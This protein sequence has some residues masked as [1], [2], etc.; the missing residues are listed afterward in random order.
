MDET[1]K[2]ATVRAAWAAALENLR[3]DCPAGHDL[4]LSKLSPVSYAGGVLTV[5][6]GDE[7]TRYICERRLHRMLASELAYTAGRPITL[8]YVLQDGGAPC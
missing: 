5:A 8:Y 2:P 4:Y 3:R 6:A 7:R 1:N